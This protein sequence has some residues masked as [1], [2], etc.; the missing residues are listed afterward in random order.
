MWER[1]VY[2]DELARKA[3]GR[4]V[5]HTLLVHFNLLNALFL[6]DLLAMFK[7]KGW[8]LIDV[9]EAFKDPI[10]SAEPKIVPAG[11]SIVWAIAKE[12]GRFESVLRYPGEDSEYEN[13]KMDKL[14]L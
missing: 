10:F 4:S 9:A 2:Y 13:A 3:L 1:A 11:E 12:T 6:G 14:G 7:G 5:K 8:K